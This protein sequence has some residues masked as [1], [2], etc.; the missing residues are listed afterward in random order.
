[1]G[2]SYSGI[3]T[4]LDEPTVVVGFVCISSKNVNNNVAINT[5]IG[6]ECFEAC[7]A[8]AEGLIDVYCD[9]ATHKC[10]VRLVSPFD[11]FGSPKAATVDSK[12]STASMGIINNFASQA[13]KEPG[14]VD[15]LN[16]SPLTPG[17]I[18]TNCSPTA[19]DYFVKGL[20]FMFSVC[21]VVV[22]VHPTGSF[23]THYIR[24]FRILEDTLPILRNYVKTAPVS[25]DQLVYIYID[26]LLKN[27]CV[28]VL[29]I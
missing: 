1:M 24:L 15:E 21:H 22:L 16:Q 10:Y 14:I 8:P 4:G 2:L 25:I 19:D 11:Y 5:I 6:E 7:T 17:A 9:E 29:T 3:T 18:P 20:L 26:R 13:V 23:N 12:N 28:Y 27:S